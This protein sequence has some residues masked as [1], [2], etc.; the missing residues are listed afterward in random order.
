MTNDVGV[1]RNGK[2]LAHAAATLQGIAE[3]AISTTL[4]NMASAALLITASAA[5]RRESRGGHMREDFPLTKPA[6]AKRSRLTLG[7]A[8]SAPRQTTGQLPGQ[9]I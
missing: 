7:K 2:G 6:L 1:I 5:A 8:G 9:P 4:I 3:K